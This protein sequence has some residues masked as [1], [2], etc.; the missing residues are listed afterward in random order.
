[1]PR[2]RTSRCRCKAALRPTR[3]RRWSRRRWMRRRRSR[4]CARRSSGN[5]F[6][7][8][9]NGRR[10]Q[11]RG[12]RQLTEP[13]R[14]R[15]LPRLCARAASARCQRAPRPDREDRPR[16]AGHARAGP[17]DGHQQAHPQHLRRR[18]AG[19]PRRPVRGRH[20]PR[21]A[22]REPFQAGQRRG[23]RRRRALR[24][25]AALGRHRVL[26][27]DAALALHR[28]HE[29]EHPRRAAG[30]VQSVCRRTEGRGRADRHA[31]VPQRRGARR[32]ASAT[33]DHRGAHLLSARRRQDAGRAESAHRPQ[34]PRRRAR[35]E[36]YPR[37][38]GS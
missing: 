21:R 16:R 8:Y 13:R 35:G 28:E 1:M 24:P 34:R 9:I 23:R 17:G 2:R 3:S 14:R 18:Q 33:A 25:R 10:R 6:A 15:S 32:D 20:L 36:L 26:L 5:T 38:A 11:G 37:A 22:G 7:L 30:A 4:S 27:H 31:S 12:R 19:R 29:D